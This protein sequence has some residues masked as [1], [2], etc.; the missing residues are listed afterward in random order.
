MNGTGFWDLRLSYGDYIEQEDDFLLMLI[1]DKMGLADDSDI[2]TMC[3]SLQA[4]VMYSYTVVFKCTLEWRLFLK[5][6]V[7]QGTFKKAT[8]A[9][10]P[11]VG[12]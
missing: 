1:I 4:A 6:N 12:H 11:D 2:L 5:G 10:R 8:N 9:M 3:G 7:S